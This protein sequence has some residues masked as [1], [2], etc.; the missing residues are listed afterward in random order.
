MNPFQQALADQVKARHDIVAS[1]PRLLDDLNI[2]RKHLCNHRA[3]LSTQRKHSP[4]LDLEVES[5]LTNAQILAYRFFLRL[6][7]DWTE[8]KPMELHSEMRWK[9]DFGPHMRLLH[10]PHQTTMQ[11]V[12]RLQR[13]SEIPSYALFYR[14]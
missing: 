9:R 6:V 1:Y 10:P 4:S 12:I 3:R 5:R 7:M 13:E 2:A 8:M 14:A 11:E